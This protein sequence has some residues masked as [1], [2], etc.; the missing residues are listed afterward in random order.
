[1]TKSE[2]HGGSAYYRTVGGDFSKLKDYD[3]TIDAD[4]LDAWFDPSPKAINKV[5]EFL[6]LLLKK[7]PPSHGQGLVRV[8]AARRGLSPENI[9]TAGGSSDIMFGFFP[10]MLKKGDKV[11]I[12]DPMYGEYAHIFQ[13]VLRLKVF[14][15]K[16]YGSEGFKINPE[17]LKQDIVKV[18]P[19]IVVLV[20]PNSPTGQYL[21]TSEIIKL[22]KTLPRVMF[23]V[24]ETYI[25]YVGEK[26][27]LEKLATRIN[28]L[29][30]MKSMS[31]V[32]ALSGARVGYLVASRKTIEKVKPFFPPWAVSLIGQIAAIEA[33]KDKK[34]YK[35]KYLQTHRLRD[36]MI[37]SLRQIERI[38]VFN[39]VGNFFLVHLK[40]ESLS[41][42]KIISQLEDRGVFLRNCDSMGLQFHDD[43]IRIA[44]RD[45]KSNDRIVSS[46]KRCL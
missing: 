31:K 22:A 10:N 43:Y 19:K 27:S 30:I 17:R 8:L 13:N 14:R 45:K 39:S 35:N 28:N 16:L 37:K 3:K 46:L 6:P 23:V 34:Y 18:K 25:E 29:V 20:N 11:L 9:I 44:V 5:K 33:L 41:A 15:H 1:M 2:F 24:D 7:T 40:A 4:G 21:R 42:K 26:K 38:E 32:Y 36:A 12:L